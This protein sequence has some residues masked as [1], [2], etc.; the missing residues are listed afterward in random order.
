ML[1]NRTVYY[2]NHKFVFEKGY[3]YAKGHVN[4]ELKY[5]HRY[6]WE[7][8]FG[9]IPEGYDIHHID[10]DKRNNDI[11]NLQMLP[12]R[13]HQL[14]HQAMKTDEQKQKRK[15]NLDK[16]RDLTK[17][18]HASEEGHK[19]HK[20]HYEKMKD[21]LHVEREFVCEICGEKFVSTHA[22][23]RFCSN[24]CRAAWRRKS[25]LDNESRV[26]LQCGK[27]FVV[28]KYSKQKFCSRECSVDNKRKPKR[29]LLRPFKRAV[30]CVE[31]NK[32]FESINDA[33]RWV[34]RNST[35]IRR[36]CRGEEKTCGGYHWQ[37][38]DNSPKI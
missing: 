15:E 26:C 29:Q 21:K 38:V 33:S 1:E 20:E 32:V 35:S 37:Y 3:R 4:G 6:V 11:T 14:L 17:E 27:E 28:N 30:L 13:E 36:C 7:C 9:V 12:E 31:L 16:I 2:N 25:G 8:N 19:W 10:F 5:L 34:G 18:W 24:K 23:C 22:A